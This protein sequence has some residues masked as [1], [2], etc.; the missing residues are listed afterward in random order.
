MPVC[1]EDV[2]LRYPAV[3]HLLELIANDANTAEAPKRITSKRKASKVV[4]VVV[5]FFLQ[6][7]LAT[8]QDF[9]CENKKRPIA[10]EAPSIASFQTVSLEALAKLF[11]GA[12]V[13]L[14][15]EAVRAISVCI[16]VHLH[17][18]N[19]RLQPP[20]SDVDG[21]TPLSSSCWCSKVPTH[22]SL[23]PV[24][25]FGRTDASISLMHAVLA[26]NTSTLLQP[27]CDLL[28]LIKYISG[29]VAFL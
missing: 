19:Q 12:G 21:S 2:V 18:A 15:P 11:W 25:S 24:S 3:S 4:N 6:R 17:S 22:V 9:T 28:P 7:L 14:S 20:P 29:Y 10:E 5:R 26:A 8:I 16:L 1:H 13:W 23:L 27:T